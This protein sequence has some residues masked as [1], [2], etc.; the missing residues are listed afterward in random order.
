MVRRRHQIVNLLGEVGLAGPMIVLLLHHLLSSRRWW[1]HLPLKVVLWAITASFG[2][3]PS[4]CTAKLGKIGD[5]LVAMI[6]FFRVETRAQVPT[7]QFIA[8]LATAVI[9]LSIAILLHIT[10]VRHALVPTVRASEP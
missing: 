4:C 8:A 9:G 10:N 1:R 6:A 7:A 2:A 3:S 5:F